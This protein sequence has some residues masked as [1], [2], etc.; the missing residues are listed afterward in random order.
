VSCGYGVRRANL[1]VS[2]QPINKVVL[3]QMRKFSGGNDEFSAMDFPL[4]TNLIGKSSVLPWQQED[5]G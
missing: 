5:C 4:P 3:L 2:L 1:R